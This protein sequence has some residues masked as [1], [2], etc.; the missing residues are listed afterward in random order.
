L[1][2]FD[3]QTRSRVMSRSRSRGSKSTEWKFRS[4]LMRSRVTG[5]VLGHGSGV[6]G[7]PDVIF[8]RHRI[9]IF[10]DGCLWHGCKRCR[11]IPLT[12][13]SF[14]VKKINRNRGRDKTVVRLLRQAGW[15]VLR[16]WEHELRINRDDALQKVLIARGQQLRLRHRRGRWG[17]RTRRK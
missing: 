11:T 15:L 7:N 8:P 3:P 17:A 4:L 1:D 13:R 9:A 10:L 16:I 2:R 12:N 14:W 6:F 5:W